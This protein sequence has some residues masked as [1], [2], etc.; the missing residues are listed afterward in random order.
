MHP[1]LENIHF[2]N[3]PLYYFEWR[4]PFFAFK[5]SFDCNKTKKPNKNT[6]FRGSPKN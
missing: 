5:G 6:I 2:E 3:I 1:L 4:S